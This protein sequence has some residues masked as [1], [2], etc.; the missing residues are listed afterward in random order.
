MITSHCERCGTEI[1]RGGSI[2]GR[3]CSRMCAGQAKR[4]TKPVSR[5]W[6]AAKYTDEGLG[7]V[8]IGRLVGRHPKRVYE[9]LIGYGIPL[10]A[11]WHGNVPDPKPFHDP[12]WL[13]AEYAKGRNCYTIAAEFGVVPA[14]V[15]RYMVKAGIETRTSVESTKLAGKTVRLSGAK[16]GMFGRKGSLSSNWKGGVTPDRQAFY[17]TREWAEACSQVW[18]RDDATCQRCG[19]RKTSEDQEYSVYHIVTFAVKELRS[20]PTNLILLCKPCRLWV[21]SNQNERRQFIREPE[22]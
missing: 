18:K 16:N 6:L 4:D 10:R 14:T 12:E 2:P 17:E 8:Q 11:K 9:W 5:E 22:R 13:K 15:F 20:E 3:F 19:A 7:T 21:H 1:I